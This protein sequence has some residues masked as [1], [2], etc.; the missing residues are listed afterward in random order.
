MFTNPKIKQFARDV[1]DHYSEW[2]G[3]GRVKRDILDAFRHG[4]ITTGDL[5]RWFCNLA[6]TKEGYTNE[7]WDDLCRDEDGNNVTAELRFQF[8]LEIANL[9]RHAVEKQ[10]A[11][12]TQKEGL[13]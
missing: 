2:H 7:D 12:Q 1:F 11:K 5:Q 10:Q 4:N 9:Y 8:R 6:E 13:I 3:L